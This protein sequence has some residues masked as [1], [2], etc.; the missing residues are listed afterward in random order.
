MT[1]KFLLVGIMAGVMTL[2]VTPTFAATHNADSTQYAQQMSQDNNTQ[3][4]GQPPHMRNGE[5]PP[6]PPKDENGNP[7]PPPDGKG[8]QGQGQGQNGNQPPE[9]PKDENGNPLPPPDGSHP[10]QHNGQDRSGNREELAKKRESVS[11]LAF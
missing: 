7:L 3:R 9:P 4:Q 10:S 11:A 8:V 6:E 1:K 5:Q 2:G